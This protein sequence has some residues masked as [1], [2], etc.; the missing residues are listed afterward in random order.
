MDSAAQ[1]ALMVKAQSVFGAD[2]TFLSFPVAPL[3][4]TR[5]QLDFF[6][7]KD[8]DDLRE[9]LR[10]LQSFSTTVNLIPEGEAWVPTEPRFLWD[11]YED[12]LSATYA[13]SQR[14]ADE[15]AAYQQALGYL[16]V[17]AAGGGWEDSAPVR[18]YKQ[19][20]DAYLIAQQSLA[21][22]MAT[23]AAS[24]DAAEA[25]RWR[26][27]E[28]PARRAELAAL[29]NAW[30]V[31]G[32]KNEVES[33]QA[34]VVSLGS[35]SPIQVWDE[36]KR[37]FNPD[38]D[39]TTSATD[40]SRAYPSTFSPTNAIDD[41]AWKPFTL[42]ESEIVSLVNQAPADLKERMGVAGAS[43][44]KS[45][46]FEF[47]SATIVRPWF[48]PDAFRARFWKFT[49]DTPAICD[50]ATPPAGTC[51]AYV[52]AVVFARRVIVEQKPAATP[53]PTPTPGRFGVLEGFQIKP[54]STLPK[55]LVRDHRRRFRAS[56][57]TEVSGVST[58]ARRSAPMIGRL[59]AAAVGPLTM[60]VAAS[61]AVAVQPA[62]AAPVMT[63]SAASLG[64]LKAMVF[65]RDLKPAPATPVE[66]DETIS[67]LAFICKRNGMCPN[68]DPT[69]QW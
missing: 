34:R 13:S 60:H 2:D 59:R 47:S 51:P 23:A 6:S 64:H 27:L 53:T 12:V 69:L 56:T 11:V 9:S 35:R 28:E 39:E 24:T 62:P 52:T 48:A 7:Q 44:L 26:T 21:A 29:E 25:E 15:E 20:K 43:T 1:L 30:I 37:R 63:V 42:S 33:A 31:L 50:G 32:H 46:G 61:P 5:R 67:I 36:W 65:T 45:V 54:G 4:Y 8:A 41:G 40:L 49:D 38:L 17:A 68:P 66:A 55:V 3:P 18:A 58:V 14:T 16:R 10:H 19:H 22:A 57:V